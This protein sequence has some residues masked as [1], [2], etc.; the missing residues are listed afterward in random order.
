MKQILECFVK[1][2]NDK[3]PENELSVAETRLETDMRETLPLH[4][5]VKE[6]LSDR[7]DLYVKVGEPQRKSTGLGETGV[8][9]D[10]R[11]RVCK[12]FGCQKKF[13]LATNFEGECRHHTKPPVFHETSKYWSCCPHKKAYDWDDFMKIEGCATSKHS[14]LKPTGNQFLGGNELRGNTNATNLKTVEAFNKEQSA[15]K[16]ELPLDL[17]KRAL[18]SV[19]C[20]PDDF[21]EAKKQLDLKFPDKP[22][23]VIAEFATE[24]G[25]GLHN[26]IGTT[27][28]GPSS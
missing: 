6:R 27:N 24:L 4:A 20:S 28:T 21:D 26:L 22:Q 7:A 19:G 11:V 15:S 9:E 25:F 1:N 16:E 5:V 13:T 14:D 23:E 10:Q 8:D 12:N 3:H 2:Y 17:L 18:V